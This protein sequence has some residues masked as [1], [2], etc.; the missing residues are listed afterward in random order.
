[1]CDDCDHNDCEWLE[2]KEK[3]ILKLEKENEMLKQAINRKDQM[4]EYLR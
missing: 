3:V 1:M 2:D 4:I